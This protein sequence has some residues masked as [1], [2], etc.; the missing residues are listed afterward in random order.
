[1]NMNFIILQVFNGITFGMLIFLLATGLTLTLGLMNV[2]NLAHG[3]FYMLGGY[4]GF[5]VAL[6]T[7]NFFLGLLG[8]MISIW[9][10]GMIMYR[11]LLQQHFAKEEL[12]QMLLC[13]GVILI[14]S[15]LCL[16]IWGGYPKFVV[17]PVVFKSSIHLGKVVLPTYRLI[18]IMVGAIMALFL[19]WFQGKTRYGAI[20]R[21][22]V[23][24]E[25]MARGV[26]INIVLVRLLV[27]SLGTALAAC[28]GFLGGPILGLYP[29]IDVEVLL[30]AIVVI[31]IG[32]VGSLKGALVGALFIGLINS[33]GK[34]LFPEFAMFT[35]FAPMA[36]VLAIRP[37]GLFGEA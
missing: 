23:D 21:A 7:G 20:I 8:S 33:F 28:A 22:G 19:W 1:M 16:W 14:V 25:E 26:G 30:M 2:A 36:I 32:G 17:K 18:V 5:S 15:D 3:S 27:F 6:Y 12:S 37:S 13:F 9:V 11:G 4:I 31:V 35:I 34:S 10:G 24:D 29:G